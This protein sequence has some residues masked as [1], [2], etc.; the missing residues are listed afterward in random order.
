MA[1]Q[2]VDSRRL[3]QLHVYWQIQTQ[4]LV[5][6]AELAHAYVFDGTEGILL[7]QKPEPAMWDTI[8][9]GWDCFME[10]I[11]SDQPPPLSERDTRMRDDP[12]WLSAAAAYLE[13][14]TAHEELSAKVDE[15]KARLVSLSDHPKEHG[16]GVAVTRSW[17]RGNVD[18]KRVPELSNVDLEQLRSTARE[19]VRVPL[20]GSGQHGAVAAWLPPPLI[21][22]TV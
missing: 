5:S 9:H 19:E 14:R 8:R 17:K 6:K 3:G 11:R 7:A 16:G 1:N 13:L 15:A 2:P 20:N 4:L 22:R 12:E 18:Y 21:N 10:Y